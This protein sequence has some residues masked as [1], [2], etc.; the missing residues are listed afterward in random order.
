MTRLALGLILG[1]AA[2]PALAEDMTEAEREALRAEIRAYL[3]ENP[4]VLVEAMSVLQERED[5]AALERDKM[6]VVSQS[7]AL[8]VNENDWVGGNPDGDVTVVEFMDYRCGYCRK[9]YDEVEALVNTDG[10]IRFVVKEFPIL[11][12]A[13]LLSSQFAISVLQ[14]HGSDAYK[15]VHDGLITLRG[16]PTPETLSRL[17]T[18]LGLD[19]KP[20]I[21]R[22][23]SPEVMAVIQA[24]HDLAETMEV[25]GTPAFITLAGI[26]RGY[27][28]LETMQGFVAE[29][30]AK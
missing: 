4:E 27:A 1:L 23:A 2:L 30:R 6:L 20:I 13:S 21:D 16:E 7:D 17:A 28:P 29:A 10:N 11:G 22:M 25:T 19:P 14:L 24:N 3:L 12:D 26:M 5:I 15:S 9:A 18:D 8:F